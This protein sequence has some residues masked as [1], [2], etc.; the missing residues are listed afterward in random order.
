MMRVEAGRMG[1]KQCS[2][3]GL[4]CS[5]PR[6][7]QLCYDQRNDQKRGGIWMDAPGPY[8]FENT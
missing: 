8:D 2:H 5:V 4:G 6:T 7:N 1:S 3:G